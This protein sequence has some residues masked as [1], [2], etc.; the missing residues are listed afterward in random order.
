MR[1]RDTNEH[2]LKSLEKGQQEL[3]T[4]NTKK[5]N[6]EEVWNLF[7]SHQTLNIAYACYMLDGEKLATFF[8]RNFYFNT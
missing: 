7:Y 1:M 4:L 3:D 2:L 5:D 6:L 8:D